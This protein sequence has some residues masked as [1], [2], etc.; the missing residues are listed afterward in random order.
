MEDK[1]SMWNEAGL[2]GLA[3]GGVSVA[4]LA[5]TALTGKAAADNV[6]LSLLISGLN[7]I[8]WIAKFCF[9]IFL[10]KFFLKKRSAL[11]PEEGNGAIFRFGSA[12]ALLS[13]LVYSACY[14]AY[15]EFLAPDMF[16]EAID[17]LKDNPMMGADAMDSIEQMMPKMPVYLFF[18][19]FFYC[20]AF[21]TILS[22]ILSRNIPPVNPFAGDS[23]TVDEQ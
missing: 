7:M 12:V 6:G 13:A 1:K 17:M 18:I 22:A 2:A 5:L 19:N 15:F 9:C 3:L 16:T 11:H 14:L 23:D 4:Y 10:M 8:L 21:G 20:W